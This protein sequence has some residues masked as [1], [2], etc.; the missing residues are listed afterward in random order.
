MTIGGTWWIGAA[1]A[2]LLSACDCGGPQPKPDGG[3]DAGPD[4]GAD[5]GC[6]ER[7][8][9]SRDGGLGVCVSGL[10]VECGFDADC[11]SAGLCFRA[12]CA[13]HACV[14][15]PLHDADG[16]FLSVPELS[17]EWKLSNAATP[18][19]ATW[20]GADF[21]LAFAQTGVNITELKRISVDG[22]LSDAFLLPPSLKLLAANDARI[23]AVFETMA[24]GVSAQLLSS[25]GAAL[26]S[27]PLEGVAANQPRAAGATASP[28]GFLVNWDYYNGRANSLALLSNGAALT[29]GAPLK[30]GLTDYSHAG[31]SAWNGAAFVLA[32][33]DQQERALNPEI[34]A[35]TINAQAVATPALGVPTLRSDTSGA[36][37]FSSPELLNVGGKLVLL[38]NNAGQKI[39]VAPIDA[40]LSAVTPALVLASPL[41]SA[42]ARPLATHDGSN[43]LV[44]VSTGTLGSGGF[45]RVTPGAVKLDPTPVI[46]ATSAATDRVQLG[47]AVLATDGAGHVLI[48]Y[49]RFDGD[50]GMPGTYARLV[51]TCP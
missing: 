20:N 22:G 34:W 7:A 32:W 25:T 35:A 43:V 51:R 41:A 39:A 13:N 23:L 16:G 27:F 19:A 18:I 12:R 28:T 50:A 4:A 46:F 11:A 3:A 24:D 6:P 45:L 42:T 29:A 47:S 48:G 44:F 1:A 37:D 31:R 9:C 14:N 36:N 15:D 40:T 8:S 2:M 30:P 49:Q 33:E 38:A 17:T 21:L 26:G 5:A 10:C